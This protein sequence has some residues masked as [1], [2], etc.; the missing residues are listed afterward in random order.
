M[1]LHIDDSKSIE[2]IQNQFIDV[3]KFI[4]IEFFTKSHNP[5][6]SSAK[7][8]LIEISKKL[9]EI[10]SKHNEGDLLITKE[11]TVNDVEN[12]FE[13]KFGVHVQVFRKQ[14]D[15]WLLTTNIDDWTLEKQIETAKF[16]S[17]PVKD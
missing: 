7:K 9:G 8:D 15:V 3:F 16:M 1:K 10:R 12:S 5:G 4:K 2:E 17:S 6:E 14:N 13:D 11:M